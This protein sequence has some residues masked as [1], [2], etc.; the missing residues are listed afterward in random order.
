MSSVRSVLETNLDG[1]TSVL[2]TRLE[3]GPSYQRFY[4]DHASRGSK[5]QPRT[6]RLVTHQPPIIVGG[7]SLSLYISQVM[8]GGGGAGPFTYHATGP[9]FGRLTGVRVIHERTEIEDWLYFGLPENAELWLWTQVFRP[10]QSS[11]EPLA[12]CPN[13]KI[14]GIPSGKRMNRQ[15]EI[16]TDVT[17]GTARATNAQ[18]RPWLYAHGG[19]GGSQFRIGAY[20]VAADGCVLFPRCTT[21]QQYTDRE[22]DSYRFYLGFE[23]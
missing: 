20:A 21:P 4:L 3:G 14:R 2:P 17:M 15:V 7:G 10:L 1:V 8:T 11:W 18:F 5:H 22:A 13:I 23:H 6:R 16:I 9:L 12:S 19:Y